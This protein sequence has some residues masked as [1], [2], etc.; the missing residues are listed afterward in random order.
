[1]HGG[2]PSLQSASAVQR[3]LLVVRPSENSCPARQTYVNSAPYTASMS[4][5]LSALS[6][7]GIKGQRFSVKEIQLEDIVK[8]ERGKTRLTSDCV[9]VRRVK[10]LKN[11]IVIFKR[12]TSSLTRP[13]YADFGNGVT[14]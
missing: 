5:D 1:M 6:T 3:I 10:H 8:Q 14:I 11:E 12:I 4:P 13:W 2:S 9:S 7:V